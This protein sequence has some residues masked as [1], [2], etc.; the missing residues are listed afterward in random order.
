MYTK[1]LLPNTQVSI[2]EPF[3]SY[4]TGICCRVSGPGTSPSKPMHHGTCD[5][6]KADGPGNDCQHDEVRID[7]PGETKYCSSSN[8]KDENRGLEPVSCLA[9]VR[10]RRYCATFNDTSTKKYSRGWIEYECEISWIKRMNLW[11]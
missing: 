7:S 3:L 2:Y 1:C 4:L 6:G 9:P 10:K 5:H 11:S 8:G